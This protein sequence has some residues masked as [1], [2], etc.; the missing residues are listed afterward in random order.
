M[1]LSRVLALLATIATL[2]PGDGFCQ[3]G[4]P[5]SPRPIDLGARGIRLVAPIEGPQ[6]RIVALD[7]PVT[8]AGIDSTERLPLARAVQDVDVAVFRDGSF[9]VLAGG[10]RE[11]LDIYRFDPIQHVVERH[12]TE[13]GRRR[14]SR[15]A[16]G[17]GSWPLVVGPGLVMFAFEAGDTVRFRAAHVSRT[18]AERRLPLEC[19]GFRVGFD[20]ESYLVRV[21]FLGADDLA[22]DQ[23][24]FVHPIAPR[25]TIEGVRGGIVAFDAP[26]RD[27]S[28]ERA[29]LL[30][31]VGARPLAFDLAVEG[32]FEFEAALVGT[33]SLRPDEVRQV[34]LRFPGGVAGSSSGTLRL[35]SPVAGVSQLLTLRATV[36]AP[37]P[38]PVLQP[39]PGAVVEVGHAA[40]GVPQPRAR[41]APP[42]VLKLHAERALAFR[43]RDEGEVRV[44]IRLAANAPRIDALWIRNRR[45]G[46]TVRA[47][48]ELGSMV[49]VSLAAVAHDPIAVATRAT[50][51]GT[52]IGN[53]PPGL[54]LDGEVVVI[55]AAPATSFLLVEVASEGSGMRLVGA[56]PAWQGRTD[57]AGLARVHAAALRGWVDATSLALVVCGVDGRAVVSTPIELGPSTRP[58]DDD[59]RK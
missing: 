54:H 49:V 6:D 15:F 52:W 23:L 19:E 42:P 14:P 2:I 43:W 37:P 33:Q 47:R 12:P 40:D 24:Q 32:P 7:F 26:A 53:V 22:I 50:D 34:T 17:L 9:A 16:G 29:L 21:D 27:R 28:V 13:G 35:T 1:S 56:G 36:A 30:R 10:V 11:D 8:V 3:D 45:S 39:P 46:E 25:L 57:A 55:H 44:T 18:I 58:S 48:L 41:V 4:G 51:A 59:R 38:E 20:P 31:N 5:S